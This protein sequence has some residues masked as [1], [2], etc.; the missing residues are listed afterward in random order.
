MSQKNGFSLLRTE[1]KVSSCCY[2]QDLK[3]RLKSQEKETDFR[4]YGQELKGPFSLLLEIA[5]KVTEERIS[6]LQTKSKV[7]F[8]YYEKSFSILKKQ[9]FAGYYELFGFAVLQTLTKWNIQNFS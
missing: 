8:R 2:G 1:V 6:L 5:A 7:D 4:Y 3:P 9:I